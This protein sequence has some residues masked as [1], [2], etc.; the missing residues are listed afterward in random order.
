MHVVLNIATDTL[1]RQ[2]GEKREGCDS[3]SVGV[4]RLRMENVVNIH[5]AR[6]MFVLAANVRQFLQR[7]RL[8]LKKF[9]TI[10]PA[11]GKFP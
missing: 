5:R 10:I 7:Y 3:R 2:A 8:Q 6:G 11:E 4:A 9:H 1:Y